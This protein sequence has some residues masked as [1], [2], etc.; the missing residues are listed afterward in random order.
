MHIVFSDH[1]IPGEI[2]KS[3]FLAGP[4]PRSKDVHDWRHEALEF[5]KQINFEGTVF[6]PI[7][8]K[9]FYGQD[10]DPAWT[11][12]NQIQW[13]CKA[14]QV[15]DK[16][17]F[18]VPRDIL[19][20]MPAFTT[21]VEFGEDLHSGKIVYG[22]PDNAEKCKYLDARYLETK[23]K[24]FNDLQAMLNYTNESLGSG[25]LRRGGEVHVP[26]FI[27][28]TEQFQSWYGNLQKA[29]NKLVDAKVLHYTS[30]VPGS[31]F[32]FILAVN[33]WVEKEGRFKSNEFI[34]SR[35]DISTVI[36][37]HKK[38]NKTYVVLIKEFRSPVNNP[39][40]FVIE[41]PGGSSAKEGI[42]PKVNAQH[43]LL[44]EAGLFISD[45][46]RFELVGTKQL[47]ATLSTHVSHVYKVEL[48]AE[49]FEKLNSMYQINSSYGSEVE[50]E[51]TYLQIFELSQLANSHVDYSTLGMIF[52]ALY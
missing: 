23:Q 51:K 5:L 38:D 33:V 6:V 2:V 14:R 1:P 19:G 8:E 36:A 21:N 22:R 16:I 10:D 45:E 37:Y 40:G 44:E 3:L 15:S 46:N 25:Q 48:T 39:S 49:E 4:S 41:L 30:F 20:G 50:S 12:I 32:S 52:Q 27:W 43:E 7:P 17:V 26:L 29:K 9:R 28:Q 18:W 13:E 11:Y 24:I 47:A 31:I 35:K 34:F 42:D